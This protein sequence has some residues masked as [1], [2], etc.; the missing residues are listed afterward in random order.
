VDKFIDTPIK[1]YSSGMY[2]R[3]AFAVA[4]HLEPDILVVDEVLA[5]GDAEFQK[6]CLGKMDEVSRR[7]GRTVL[8]VSHNLAAITELADR[9]LLLNSGRIA[10]D[11]SVSDALSTYLSKVVLT[12]IYLRPPEKCRRTPHIKR[13]EVLTSDPN[14]VHHFGQPLEIKFLIKHDEP[15]SRGC[16]SFQIINQYQQAAVH[17]F[18]YYPDIHFGSV[19][20]ETTLTCRFPSLQLNVGRFHLRTFLTEPPG[21][22]VYETIDDICSFEVTRADKQVLWGWRPEACIYHEEYAWRTADNRMLADE[23]CELDWQA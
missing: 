17:A 11:G 2:V 19:P 8:L 21:G 18:A 1:R 10:L 3:L 4:A 12:P 13:A 5:V 7:E 20:G 9:A 6:K 15:M 14:G 16:F 22:K 23:E